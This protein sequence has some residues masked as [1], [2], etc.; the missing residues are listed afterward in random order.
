MTLI[1]TGIY[2]VIHLNKPVRPRSI[3]IP[4]YRSIPTPDRSI[5]RLR[6]SGARQTSFYSLR[7]STSSLFSPAFSSFCLGFFGTLASQ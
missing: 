3:F 5:E 7:G 1:F 2:M 6:Y 4:H